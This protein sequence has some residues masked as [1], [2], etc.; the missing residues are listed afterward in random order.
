VPDEMLLTFSLPKTVSGEFR[1]DNIF[2]KDGVKWAEVISEL[3]LQYLISLVALENA[4]SK[5]T[6]EE[7][8]RELGEIGL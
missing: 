7:T 8:S 6:I 1:V 2:V 3:D 5:G 4:V